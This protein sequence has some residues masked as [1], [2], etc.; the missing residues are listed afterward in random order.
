MERITVISFE[1]TTSNIGNFRSLPIL[2]Q[3]VIQRAHRIESAG[4]QELHGHAE[5]G[6]LMWAAS[7]YWRAEGQGS[8][9]IESIGWKLS[10]GGVHF[11]WT[12]EKGA[13]EVRG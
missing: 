6:R 9:K 8:F 7:G 1:K 12:P 11:A 3:R 5:D 4:R 10:R 2:I 13:Y